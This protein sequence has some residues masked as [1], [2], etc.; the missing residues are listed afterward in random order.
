MTRFHSYLPL[1]FPLAL[2]L[3]LVPCRAAPLTV[4][5]AFGYGG[6]IHPK[7]GGKGNDSKALDGAR[8]SSALIQAPGG[9][10]YGTTLNGGA[11]GMGTVFRVNPDGTGFT[12]LHS[13]DILYFGVFS[14]LTNSGGASLSGALVQA[15]SGALYG[16]AEMGGPGSSGL[17]FRL[18][19]DGTGF[20]VIH[21]FGH[22]SGWVFGRNGGGAGPVALTLGADGLL[23]GAAVDEGPDGGGTLFRLSSDGK[24]FKVLHA[25]RGVVHG[26]GT[27][28]GGTQPEAAPVFG[29][30]GAL[31]G[32]T[33]G[34]GTDGCGVL[35]RLTTGGEQFTV[36]H[37]FR[38]RSAAA[39]AVSAAPEGPLTSAADGSLYGCTRRGGAGGGT[40]FRVKQ[41]GAD[42]TVLHTF[43]GPDD[44]GGDGTLPAATL[45]L[46]RDGRLYGL[47]SAGGANGTG[48]VF[49]VSPDG[50]K[51][52]VLHDFAAPDAAYHNADGAYPRVG[53]LQGG[54]GALYGTTASGGPEGT[55]TVFRLVP[56]ALPL[57]SAP[58]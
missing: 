14:G 16:T 15:P 43:P 56:P 55:G 22:G 18:E 10:L 35:Y 8:P 13:C 26:K 48:T 29:R 33:T 46:G 5:H 3:G 38:R 39:E 41:D 52:V 47:T 37:H 34:G 24:G 7:P 2:L 32:T 45:V 44:D 51:F 28:E 30:D 17:I 21:S 23:Y 11:H 54:D 20:K 9:A 53:L 36:L 31:Y 6:P 49:W 1:L 58:Q 27:N 42:F 12:V 4:L 40:L 19:P 50:A 57:P 25:F